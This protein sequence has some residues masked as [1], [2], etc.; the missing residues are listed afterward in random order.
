MNI[1]KIRVFQ[2]IHSHQHSF[3]LFDVTFI[4]CDGKENLHN[5]VETI[6]SLAKFN[7]WKFINKCSEAVGN[8]FHILLSAS[9]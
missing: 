3:H 7:R 6:I 8:A 5:L 4:V 9:G 1:V 2:Y